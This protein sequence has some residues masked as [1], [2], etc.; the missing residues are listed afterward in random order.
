LV[1]R[2]PQREAAEAAVAVAKAAKQSAEATLKAA[3][4]N[5][6][7]A[8]VAL[9]QALLN[10]RRTKVRAP[11]N[12]LIRER[13]VNLGGRAAGDGA[14]ATVAGTDEWWVEVSIPVDQLKWLDVPEYNSPSASSA[15]VYYQAAWGDK[16]YRDGRADRLRGDLEP[17]G[18]MAQLLVAV[19]DPMHLRE[20]PDARRPLLLNSYVR[21]ELD[22]RATPPAVRVERTSLR[23]GDK[24]WVMSDANA[25]EIRPV[26][27]VLGKDEY[28]YVTGGLEAGDRLVTSD[29]ATP[30]EG[31]PL[32]RAKRTT[33][34]WKSGAADDE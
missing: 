16:A 23:D 11:F 2:V 28:V 5:R 1:L 26:T 6:Q 9:D 17:Q 20:S 19:P 29:I 30:V 7:A 13:H 33:T 12:A 22:G 27:I 10:L 3:R 34:T 8:Q 31:M 4:S 18:R 14:V 32:R 15:K 25:L 24:V 21:V